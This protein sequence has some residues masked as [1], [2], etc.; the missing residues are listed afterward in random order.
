MTPPVRSLLPILVGGVLLVGCRQHSESI[1]NEVRPSLSAV[2]MHLSKASSDQTNPLHLS[3]EAVPIDN[4]VT[5]RCVLTNVSPNPLRIQERSLPCAGGWSLQVRGLTTEGQ[6]LP[7]RPP[8]GSII[9]AE[10]PPDI[11]VAPGETVLR[12]LSL[13]HVYGLAE[14]PRDVDVLLLWSY[15][16]DRYVSTGIALLPRYKQ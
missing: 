13:D 2:A 1:P 15:R 14:S 9:S 8:V 16:R 6:F 12:E 3:V 5:L 10:H 4:P 7:I 11:T